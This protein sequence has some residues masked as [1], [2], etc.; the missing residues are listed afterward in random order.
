[1]SDKPTIETGLVYDTTENRQDDENVRV[2]E[3]DMTTEVGGTNYHARVRMVIPRFFQNE[4]DPF[5]KLRAAIGFE[6]EWRA[7]ERIL[8]DIRIENLAGPRQ[9]LNKA[10]RAKLNGEPVTET[11]ARR[12]QGK[13][14]AMLGAQAFESK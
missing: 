9:K 4:R 5:S 8:N 6:G 10:I 2:V 3:V 11:R 14:V 13:Y 12:G 7:Y 1:M